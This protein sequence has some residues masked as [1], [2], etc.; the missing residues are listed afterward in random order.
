[1][2]RNWKPIIFDDVSNNSSNTIGDI[3]EHLVD[4][5]SIK[6][7]I[8]TDKISPI[9]NIKDKLLRF[10]LHYSH[11]SL[12]RSKCPLDNVSFFKNF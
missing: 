8:F 7:K 6:I 2:I 12:M 3:L 5:A 10:L 4:V 9:G 11:E 1:M